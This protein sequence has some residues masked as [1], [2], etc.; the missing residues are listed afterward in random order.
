MRLKAGKDVRK[1]E[2]P[3]RRPAF[4]GMGERWLS[5]VEISMEGGEK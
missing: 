5:W 2:K 4:Q 1:W 3:A